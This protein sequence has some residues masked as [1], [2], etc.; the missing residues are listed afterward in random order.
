MFD[1][2]YDISLLLLGLLLFGS[3][4]AACAFGASLR[5][6]DERRIPD[7]GATRSETQEGYVVSAVLTLLGLLI[8][9]TFALSVDRYETRRLL[10]IENA[11]ALE[12]LYLRAQL[13][14]EPHRSRFSSLVV[15]YVDNNVR[16]ADA[17]PEQTAPLLA[18]NRRMLVA[19][20]AATVPAFETIRDIDFSSTFVDSVNQV[21]EF[22]NARKSER[23]AQI[24][25]PIFAV[26]LVYTI[27]TAG[28]LGYVLVGRRGQLSG[29]SLL[30]LF[31]LTLLLL[32]DINRPT[33]GFI[34]EPREPMLRLR[35]ALRAAPPAIFRPAPQAAGAA[36]T[37]G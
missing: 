35:E 19:L 9:F 37:A 3:M 26:L 22:D 36:P 20:W 24:P 13:L 34:R 30:G 5:R 6:R 10:V 7:F 32:A 1:W 33:D 18:D 16:L 23:R 2:L 28:V 8:G 29:I 4:V 31:T 17:E 15:R 27:I 11:N 14:E 21:V 25:A 12:T